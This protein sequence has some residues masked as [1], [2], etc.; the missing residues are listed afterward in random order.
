[1]K[2]SGRRERT[3]G[4]E[5]NIETFGG[6]REGGQQVS[7]KWRN[8]KGQD[9]HSHGP[10]GKRGKEASAKVNSS[11]GRRKRD[12]GGR[13]RKRENSAPPLKRP[14]KGRNEIRPLPQ[15][16]YAE[17]RE[18]KKRDISTRKKSR[19]QRLRGARSFARGGPTSP[20]RRRRERGASS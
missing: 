11:T 1:M 14:K 2:I 16:L 7:K 18:V 10:N 17:K 5:M 19:A 4:G 9:S 12:E 6:P 20:K 15:R 13:G 8:R 3:R